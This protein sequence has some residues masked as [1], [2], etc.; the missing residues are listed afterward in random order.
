MINRRRAAPAPALGVSYRD[1]QHRRSGDRFVTPAGLEDGHESVVYLT[2]DAM[3]SFTICRQR[4]SPGTHSSPPPPP[5]TQNLRSPS[6]DTRA[7]IGS[8]NRAQDW[9]FSLQ[10]TAALPDA[11][12]AER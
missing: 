11:E 10:L 7:P 4:G 2:T 8:A 5:A 1:H 6:R 3:T 9:P 12:P